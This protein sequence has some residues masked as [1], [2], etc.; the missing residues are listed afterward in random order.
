MKAGE[1]QR[2]MP[3]SWFLPSHVTLTVHANFSERS[4]VKICV[5]VILLV[6]VD[7]SRK[8]V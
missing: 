2:S 5:I 1:L 6:L 7:L 4:V 3:L 8:I